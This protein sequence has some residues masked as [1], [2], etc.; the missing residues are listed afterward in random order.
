LFT[1]L[2]SYQITEQDLQA[3]F[4]PPEIRADCRGTTSTGV[5]ICGGA[6]QFTQTIGSSRVANNYADIEPYFQDEWRFRSNITF[7]YGLRY[8]WQNQIGSSGGVAPRLGLAWGLGK[9]TQGT[10][11]AVLRA[12]YG[13]FYTRLKQPY[14]ENALLLNGV[15]QQQYIITDPDFY[16]NLPTAAD[17]ATAQTAPTIYQIDPK[18]KTPYVMQAGVTLEK[19]LSKSANVAFTYLNSRGVHQLLSRNINAPLPP[20]Y[21]PAYRPLGGDENIFQYEP[22]GNFKQ[23]Q[24]IVNGTVRV[25]AK[26]SVFGYYTLNYANSNTAGITSFPSNQYDLAVDYGRAAFDVRNRL[27]L[28]G[29]VTLPYMFRLSPFLVASS[30]IPFNVTSGVDTFND[31]LYTERPTY[32]EFQQVLI[33]DAGKIPGNV[34]FNCQPPSGQP[35]ITINCGQS[36]GRFALNLRVSKTFGFGKKVGGVANTGGPMGGGT[37]GRGPGGPGGPGGS[38]GSRGGGGPI[39]GD[40]SSGQRY[41]LTLAVSARNL[42]NHLN[43]GAPVGVITSPIFGQANSLP[44]GPGGSLYSS[45]RIELQASFSF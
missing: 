4:A 10:P 36:P 38:R 13:I 44:T 45:R 31:S 29:T 39:G 43:E 34:S 24:F 5:P 6:S 32:A 18:W 23:N 19:Q 22:A 7:N 1:S 30:G 11:K 15:T 27:F 16:P 14:I 3:G 42:F 21:D 17:L 2:T 35:E 8:E 26:L 37:F 28:G 12:G 33:A 25:G 9:T 41:S 20:A 40:P